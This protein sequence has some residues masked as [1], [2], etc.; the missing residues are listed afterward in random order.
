[1]LLAAGEVSAQKHRWEVFSTP[2]WERWGTWYIDLT[3]IREL[4]NG[5]AAFWSKHLSRVTRTEIDCVTR[6]YR[7][8]EAI[9]YAKTD[10][11]GNQTNAETDVTYKYGTEWKAATPTSVS[12]KM[13]GVVCRV[14][15]TEAFRSYNSDT[16]KKVIKKKT[17][18]KKVV[19]RKT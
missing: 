14:Y 13:N 6:E 11:Y 4:P 2:G 1:M 7:I 19:K 18:K 12:D 8:L 3:S 15:K 10:S 5:N 9:D 17:V 16:Q